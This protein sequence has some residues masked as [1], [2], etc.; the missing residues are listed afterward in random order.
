MD[1]KL[2]RTWQRVPTI[3]EAKFILVCSKGNVCSRVREVIFPSTLLLGDPQGILH[4]A[5]EPST[6]ERHAP[7]KLD[8]EE[9]AKMVRGMEELSYEERM[10]QQ[11]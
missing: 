8:S 2:H 6:K 11:E 1:E 4:P 5:L 9:A 3:Q 10:R 7:L